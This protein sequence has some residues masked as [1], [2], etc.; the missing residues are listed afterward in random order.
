M[1]NEF[2]EEERLLI[3]A[4]FDNYFDTLHEKETVVH[5]NDL[6]KYMKRS[7][8]N[9][10]DVSRRSEKYNLLKKEIVMLLRNR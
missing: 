3:K 2:S 10:F 1:N 8:R 7:L 4:A 5:C 9:V 6:L